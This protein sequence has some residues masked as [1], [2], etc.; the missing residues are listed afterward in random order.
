MKLALWAV[1]M[2]WLVYDMATETEGPSQTLQ[3]M[4]YVLLGLGLVGVVGFVLSAT[5]RS[6][7]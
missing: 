4:R 7:S 5:K 6:G 2:G 3:I 1:A